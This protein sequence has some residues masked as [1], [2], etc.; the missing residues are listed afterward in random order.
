MCAIIHVSC[1]V[2]GHSTLITLNKR[3][4]LEALH[5]YVIH[6]SP[7][8]EINYQKKVNNNKIL[9]SAFTK[10]YKN[11]IRVHSSI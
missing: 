4:V 2:K 1:Q 3:N 6:K 9:S 5:L 8:T 7:K 11:N 10:I